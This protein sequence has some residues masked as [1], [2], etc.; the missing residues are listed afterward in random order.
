MK[1]DDRRDLVAVPVSLYNCRTTLASLGR[2]LRR[3]NEELVR[4]FT[5]MTTDSRLA[6]KVFNKY[7][8]VLD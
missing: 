4:I 1:R 7:H 3:S 5:E 8:R 6:F 2:V